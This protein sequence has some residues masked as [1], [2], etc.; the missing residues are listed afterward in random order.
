MKIIVA[1]GGTGGH[2]FPGLA[3][4]RAL[5][6]R[7]HDVTVWL[8]GRAVEEAARPAWDGPIWRTGAR[9]LRARTVIV[10]LASVFRCMR[11][12]RRARPDRML[13]MGS[14]ASLPPTVAA[15]LCGVPVVLHEAN[16][17]PGQAVEWLSRLARVTAV[18]FSGTHAALPGRRVVLTGLP[19]RRELAVARCPARQAQGVAVLVT[20]G[21]QGAH[22][23]NERCC[24]ALCRLRA[25]GVNG[26]R[27]LHQSGA[28]DADGLR[29]RYAAAGVDAQ[30]VPFIRDMG[31]AYAAADVAVCRAGAVTCAELCLC[32]VPAVLIPL[33]GAVRDHQRHN[34]AALAIG[35]G[36]VVADQDEL[37]DDT[38]ADLLHGLANDPSR[39][40][41]MTAALLRLAVPDADARLAD[42]VVDA[43]G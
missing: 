19:V 29:A 36:A 31:A 39:R 13:A 23:V 43:Q 1:C 9:P 10:L 16:T 42:C 18:S 25:Q 26:L 11:Q 4:A 22:A 28:A 33:P 34:A 17:V 6:E 27:V 21:S 2:V 20:G 24:G 41:S 5:R 40:A 12:V 32:G 3:T 30:V 8:S 7:G 15:W 14:Y 37:T 35:G 38:L